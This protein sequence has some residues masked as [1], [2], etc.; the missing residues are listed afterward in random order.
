MSRGSFEW[1][2]GYGSLLARRADDDPEPTPAVLRGFRRCWDVAMDNE[3]RIP[4]YK[5][6]VDPE[7]GEQPPVFVTFLN[8]QSDPGAWING[9]LIP[10]RAS[11]LPSVDARERNYDRRDVTSLVDVD[12]DARVWAYVGS[13]GGRRRY[14]TG[15]ARGTAVVSA[16]YLAHVEE[17]FASFGTRMLEHFRLT[18]D[19][20]EVPLVPLRRVEVAVA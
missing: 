17:G 18:T 20:P 8:I 16:E 13:G 1:I 12:V 15:R 3:R 4:G 6:F 5:A 10:V 2:F 14:R 11:D 19:P 7:S 9:V